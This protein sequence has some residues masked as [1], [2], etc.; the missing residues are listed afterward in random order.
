MLLVGHL[1]VPAMSLSTIPGRGNQFPKYKYLWIYHE[2]QAPVCKLGEAHLVSP[3]WGHAHT[4]FT[5]CSPLATL[6]LLEEQIHS[7]QSE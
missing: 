6:E 5:Y 3:A 2:F 4:R 1:E 7:A